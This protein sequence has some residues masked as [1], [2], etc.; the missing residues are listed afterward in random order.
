MRDR[1]QQRRAEP[2]GFGRELGPVDIGDEL[3]A[4]DGNRCLVGQRVEQALLL[5][6]QQRAL[7][8]VVEA[9]HADRLAPGPHRQIKP[10]GAGQRVGAAPGRAVMLPGPAR[11]GDIGIDQRVVGRIAGA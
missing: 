10:L 2:V 8:V 9:D 5:G 7:P 4:L 3:D 6:R 1:G 11:G